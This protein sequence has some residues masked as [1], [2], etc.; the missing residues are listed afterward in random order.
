MADFYEQVKAVKKEHRLNNEDLGVVLGM[1][2][3]A[4]RMA[5]SRESLS[6]LQKQALEQYFQSLGTKKAPDDNRSLD[7]E[8]RIVDY[9]IRNY[10]RLR[11][12]HPIASLFLENLEYKIKDKEAAIFEEKLLKLLNR[13]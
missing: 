9:F 7:D 1:T 13:Q 2:G 3:P 11:K 10:T 4:F 12:E 8:D 6:H 5:L